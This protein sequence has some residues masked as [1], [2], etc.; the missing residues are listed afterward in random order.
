MKTREFTGD[1][2][3]LIGGAA[4]FSMAMNLFLLPGGIVLGGMTGIA[5]V[6]NLYFSLPIG[7]VILVLNLPLMALGARRFGRGFLVRTLIGVGA[8]SLAAD[9]LHIFPVTVTDPLICSALGGITAGASVGILLARGYT[10][11]GTDLVVCLLK[12]ILPRVSTGVLLMLADGVII[13]GAAAILG[14]FTGIFYSIICTVT[15]GKVTDL[16]LSGARR[17]A[18]VLVITDR[19][20]AVRG[21]I[22]TELSRGV[23]VLDGRGGYSGAPKQV[24]LCVVSKPELHRLRRIVAAR[25]PDAFVI[26][27]DAAEVL[28]EGFAA[29]SAAGM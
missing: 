13:L 26:V 21:E 22:L 15:A 25:D 19:A 23:T 6:L 5:T 18:M 14:D 7:L 2:L 1:C 9:I 28:G 17:A 24:L 8:T 12:P 3:A 27:A 10:T 16:L 11:G 20:D 4:L 29:R